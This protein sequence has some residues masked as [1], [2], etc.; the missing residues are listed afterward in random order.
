MPVTRRRSVNVDQ[1]LNSKLP[2]KPVVKAVSVTKRIVTLDL[3]SDS[4]ISANISSESIIP[5]DPIS[6][7]RSDNYPD[8][9]NE[10]SNTVELAQ[11]TADLILPT[12][13][14]VVVTVAEEIKYF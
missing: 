3:H 2:P 14:T 11:P 7:P 4:A 8:S 9:D 6:A 1:R 13:D 5:T 10:S 12:V